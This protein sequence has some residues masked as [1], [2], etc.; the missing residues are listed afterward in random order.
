MLFKKNKKKL[1]ELNYRLVGKSSLDD[2]NS[3]VEFQKKLLK[4]TSTVLKNECNLV[5]ETIESNERK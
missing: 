2:T 4:W 5:N 1:G 3:R